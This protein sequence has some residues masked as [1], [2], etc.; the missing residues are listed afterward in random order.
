MKRH[1]FSGG[2][3]CRS[4][5]APT[6]SAAEVKRMKPVRAVISDVG[7]TVPLALHSE[8]VAVAAVELDSFHAVALAGELVGAALPKLNA[9]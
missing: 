6:Q 8:T 2:D 7:Q 3:G 1:R 9:E 5:N 4:T